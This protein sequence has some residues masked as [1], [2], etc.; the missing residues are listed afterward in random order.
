MDRNQRI[1]RYTPLVERIA[2]QMLVRLPPSVTWDELVSAGYIG[3]IEAVDRFDTSRNVEFSAFARTRI[4]GAMLDAL[5]ELDLL[6]RSVREKINAV[7]HTQQAL[8]QKL[9]RQPD[10]AELAEALDVPVT[11]LHDV[12]RYQRQTNLVS[13]DDTPEDQEGER[14]SVLD[15]LVDDQALSGDALLELKE[16]KNNIRDAFDGL[17]KRLRLLLVLY[18]VEALTMQEISVIMSVTVGRISQ[19]HRQGIERLREELGSTSDVDRRRLALLFRPDVHTD[20]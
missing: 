18:Y 8:E 19:L 4:R 11:Q 7:Q 3:L 2:R 1:E 14:R 12:L 5:R 17:P 13:F 6:P 9:G 10:D 20:S 16:A 15:L